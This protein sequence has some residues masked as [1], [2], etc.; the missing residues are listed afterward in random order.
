M[1]GIFS[2]IFSLAFLAAGIYL[3]IIFN[4]NDGFITEF[5]E[6]KNIKAEV[7]PEIEF[8]LLIIGIAFVVAFVFALLLG[9]S[10]HEKLRRR[11]ENNAF[12]MFL[13]I[14]S[15]I[16]YLPI[17]IIKLP[18]ILLLNFL[19]K[20]ISNIVFLI[21]AYV[22]LALGVYAF[23]IIYFN[24]CLFIPDM[25]VNVKDIL[26]GWEFNLKHVIIFMGVNLGLFA[27]SITIT[28]FNLERHYYRKRLTKFLNF[29]TWVAF[30]P[31]VIAFLPI[32]IIVWLVRSSSD[33]SY[34]SSSST[35]SSSSSGG[36]EDYGGSGSSTYSQQSYD[37][38]VGEGSSKRYLKIFSHNTDVD[39]SSP[40]FGKT[41]TRYRDDLGNFWRSY[42]GKNI[43]RETYEQ[44]SRGW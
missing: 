21:L 24:E 6:L 26:F 25:S 29:F 37:Y 18:F 14:L 35:Y 2:L 5:S 42:D 11:R 17:G 9:R 41:Y 27:I 28:H 7:Y 44:S 33:Y 19:N 13:Y 31:V 12:L 1:S 40:Y 34:S 3:V 10:S 4:F 38:T 32:S 8:S 20:K 43:I 15:W 36:Y 22:C 39:S 16:P 23:L 30:V